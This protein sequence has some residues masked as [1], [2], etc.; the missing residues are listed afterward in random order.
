MTDNVIHLTQTHPKTA[1]IW[2][3]GCGCRTHYVHE[4]G[5]VECAGCGA[6]GPDGAWLE[7]L[8]S[9]TPVAEPSFRSIDDGDPEFAR[10]RFMQ[11]AQNDAITVIA[12]YPDG[13]VGVSGE[14]IYGAEQEAWFDRRLQDAKDMILK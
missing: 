5:E 7:H 9:T 13:S 11:R 2:A 14:N 10:R 3:C 4:T 12:I 8:G 1:R 6:I